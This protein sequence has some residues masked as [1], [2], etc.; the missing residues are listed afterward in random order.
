M[1][2]RVTISDYGGNKTAYIRPRTDRVVGFSPSPQLCD[3][4]YKSKS[5]LPV[6]SKSLGVKIN[7]EMTI[8]I[9]RLSSLA[10]FYFLLRVLFSRIA[11]PAFEM[12]GP[13]Y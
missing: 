10:M 6:A 7:G 13:C 3:N 8:I 12:K 5:G 9:L 1:D 11:R 4:G 2:E